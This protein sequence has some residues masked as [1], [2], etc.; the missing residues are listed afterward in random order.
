MKNLKNNAL[1]TKIVL[2]ATAAEH[3]PAFTSVDL[4]NIHKMVKGRVYR[5]YF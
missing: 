1:P 5:Q 2:N 4:W 3:K